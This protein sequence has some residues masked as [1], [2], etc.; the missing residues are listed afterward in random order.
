[1]S[2]ERDPAHFIELEADGGRT[3][4]RLDATFLSSNWTC[5]WGEGCQGIHDTA[6]PELHDG[7]CSLGVE[8]IDED[9]AMTIAALGATLDASKFQHAD[10]RPLV[11][12]S[13]RGWFTPVVDNACVFFNK[14]GFAGGTGCALHLAA[15]AEDDD[16]IDW[17]PQTCTRMPIRVDERE[18]SEGTELTV[19]GWKR[20]DWG[21]GGQTMAW[22][23]IDAP[24]AYRGTRPVIESLAGELRVLLGDDT[25]EAAADALHNRPASGDRP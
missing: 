8:L 11:E 13:E 21:P 18:T 6:Q 25:Y 23:C 16:P 22:W 1:M 14:P 7:C 12:H 4:W 5:I 15:M 10:H 3:R 20:P 2:E 19:R 17:K 9:E 24:E